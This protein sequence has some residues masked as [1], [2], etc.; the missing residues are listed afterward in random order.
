MKAF[1]SQFILNFFA[2]VV[3]CDGKQTTKD[4]LNDNLGFKTIIETALVGKDL[5]LTNGSFKRVF[6]L[7]PNLV[8]IAFE[9][10]S[11]QQQLG[12]A[13]KSSYYNIRGT[14]ERARVC[15]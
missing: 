2:L 9:N 11:N 12:R 3:I 7:Q 4:W 10:Q 15:S 13:I 5:I 14:D 8:C 1:R 6:R